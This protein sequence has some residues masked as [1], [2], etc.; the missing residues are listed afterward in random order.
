MEAL[1]TFS[2]LSFLICEVYFPSTIMTSTSSHPFSFMGNGLA[3]SSS[4][5][6]MMEQLLV[7]MDRQRQF[8]FACVVVIAN[9]F[10]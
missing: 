3:S 8:A 5:D 1:V 9:S 10:N 7:D 6:E 4:D 2:F